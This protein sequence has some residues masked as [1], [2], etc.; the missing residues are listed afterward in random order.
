MPGEGRPQ[1]AEGLAFE[2]R[3]QELVGAQEGRKVHAPAALGDVRGA[4]RGLADRPERVAHRVVEP[5][6][7]ED[8]GDVGG[9]PWQADAVGAE[10]ID[11][12]V[13]IGQPEIPQH[14]HAD[15]LQ[16]GRRHVDAQHALGR[17]GLAAQGLHGRLQPV[18]GLR[19]HRQQRRPRRRQRQPLGPPLQELAAEQVLQP[20]DMPAERALGDV[21]RRRRPGEAQPLGHRLEGA[22]GIQRQPEPRPLRGFGGLDLLSVAGRIDRLRRTHR[23]GLPQF[24]RAMQKRYLPAIAAAAKLVLTKETA[25]AT[26]P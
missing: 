23:H 24:D 21:Q 17:A 25:C 26:C 2:A 9:R 6:P 15:H 4:G 11:R 7:V 16:E 1:H 5:R 20:A 10:E 22:Q 14:R 19:H 18:E 3:M 13:R 8:D 12:D